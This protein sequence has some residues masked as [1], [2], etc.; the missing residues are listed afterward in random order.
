MANNLA[1]VVASVVSRHSFSAVEAPTAVRI[2]STVG[3]QD[4]SDN[5]LQ[6]C[7]AEINHTTISNSKARSSKGSM[8]H[9]LAEELWA[10]F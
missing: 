8:D 6:V 1:A 9:P 10:V 7:S 5:L 4:L 2:S 3:L